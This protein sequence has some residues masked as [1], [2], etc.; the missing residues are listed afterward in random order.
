MKKETTC[1]DLSEQLYWGVMYKE[2][3]EEMVDIVATEAIM[4]NGAIA[5]ANFEL[6]LEEIE[7]IAVDDV[8][9]LSEFEY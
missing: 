5:L 4:T 2:E 1:A 3:S 6:A 8:A 9:R 7:D